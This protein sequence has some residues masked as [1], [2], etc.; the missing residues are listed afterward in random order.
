MAQTNQTDRAYDEIRRR[1]LILDI[2]PEERLKEEHW[3]K[4]I[5]VGRLAVREALTRLHGEGLVARGEKGGFFAA[6]MS[7]ADVHEIREVREIIEIAALRLACKRISAESLGLLEATCEDFAYM[8]QK[9]YHT[10]AG[11]ADRRFHHLLVAAA[12]NSRLL[13]AYEHCHIPL[14]QIRVGLS[15]EYRENYEVSDREH[16]GIVKCM[17]EGTVEEAVRLLRGQFERGEAEFLASMSA[18]ASAAR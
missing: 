6:S 1:I 8:A 13:S 5:N 7:E 2:R 16:R 12:G 18:A 11:E 14:F 3:A 15:Q 9:K 4:K 10:G 17:R